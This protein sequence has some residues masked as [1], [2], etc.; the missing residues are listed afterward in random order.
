MMMVLQQSYA[1]SLNNVIIVDERILYK[2]L[3]WWYF[4][5]LMI[6]GML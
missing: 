5:D 3:N 1:I 6:D 4:V 2:I